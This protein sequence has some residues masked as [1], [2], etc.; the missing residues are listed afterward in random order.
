MSDANESWSLRVATLTASGAE[1]CAVDGYSTALHYGDWQR[2]WAAVRERVGVFEG[3]LRRLWVL[4]GSDRVAFLQGMITADVRSLPAGRGTY[5]A[6]VTVQ[7]RVVSDLRVY[8]L[9]DELWLDVPA[10][11]AE[12]LRQH[13]ERYI[14]ADDVEFKESN[15]VS[16]A[17][18]EGRGA[19]LLIERWLGT[20]VSQLPLYGHEQISM[21]GHTIRVCAVSH[22]GER[23]WI[24]FGAPEVFPIVWQ[25]ALEQGAQP[26][27]WQAID[28]L[29][30]E[31]GFPL[32]G[33]DIDESTLIVEAE[34][35]LAISYGKGCYLGQEVVERV[36]AR[37]Q[38]Q[39]KRRGFVCRDGP[40]PERGAK[41]YLSEREVGVV[42]SAAWSPALAQVTGFAYIRREAWEPGTRL[43]ARWQGRT[44][45]VQVVGLPFLQLPVK[46]G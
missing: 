42:T 30:I 37:G 19:P 45:Q 46:F 21:E 2:E 14:V 1:L 13:L 16:L 41:L 9:D 38:V 17:I 28:A 22:T 23:G 20:E 35:E 40:A 3:S 44:T 36:A 34:M 7:G 31:A 5:A 39:R 18:V 6:A 11:Q 32:A 8:A 24:F 15:C 27:G 12:R 33:R 26:V 29:R 10:S 25:Q 43:D 4:A